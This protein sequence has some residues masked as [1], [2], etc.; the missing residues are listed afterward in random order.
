[1]ARHI[2]HGTVV[3]LHN[4]AVLLRGSSGSG[5]SDVALRLIEAGGVLISDDQVGLEKRQEKLYASSVTEIEGLLEV[6]GVGLL[7]TPF[8]HTAVV[9]LVVDLVARDAVPRLPE[10]EKVDIEGV[11][12]P[13]LRLHAFDHTIAIK[14]IKALEVAVTPEMIVK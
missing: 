11:L 4:R 5:K 10:W 1:M 7:R 12:V 2:H 8:T 13:R 9:M 6:R 3:S 14:I